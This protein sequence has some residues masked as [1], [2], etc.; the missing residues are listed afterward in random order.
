[1]RIKTLEE[2][3]LHMWNMGTD[4]E[5]RFYLPILVWGG[6]GIGKSMTVKHVAKALNDASEEMTGQEPNAR[7]RVWTQVLMLGQLELGDLIGLPREQTVYPD[8]I[9]VA[10]QKDSGEMFSR[11]DLM[12]EM[13]RRYPEE[14]KGMSGEELWFVIEE[15]LDQYASELISNEVIYATPSWF[16]TEYRR[17]KGILFLDEINRGAKDVRNAIFELLLD[18]KIHNRKLPPD[19]IIVAAANP[20]ET[21]EG[22]DTETF[23][24]EETLDPAYLDR[25]VHIVLDPSREEWLEYATQAAVNPLTGEKKY[26]K[27]QFGDEIIDVPVPRVRDEVR[28]FIADRTAKT[29]GIT[30]VDVPADIRPTPRAWDNLSHITVGMT[31]PLMLTEVA[32]GLIGPY[33]AGEWLE[34]QTRPFKTVKGIEILNDYATVV[35]VPIIDKTATP[36]ADP[37]TGEPTYPQKISDVTGQAMYIRNVERHDPGMLFYDYIH[38]RKQSAIQQTLEDLGVLLDEMKASKTDLTRVQIDNITQALIDMGTVLGDKAFAFI[39]R[40]VHVQ[41][42]NQEWREDDYLHHLVQFMNNIPGVGPTPKY[43][44]ARWMLPERPAGARA[45]WVS[46][47]S[48][49]RRPVPNVYD[50]TRWRR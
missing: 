12:L 28:Y 29:L 35:K 31:D 30:N 27:K 44:A 8:P 42:L 25:F 32:A 26:V 6:A 1:M 4:P 36:I 41:A 5:T 10:R 46:D 2:L 19:W 47:T 16:P 38:A 37:E 50:P 7:N 33:L 17:P 3:I 40:F 9:A 45:L 22:K 21:S 23:D 14:F 24:V 48:V 11:A 49:T 13:R 39:K 43:G 15:Y 34:F 18:R 20:P